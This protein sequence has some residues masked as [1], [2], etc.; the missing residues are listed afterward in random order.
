MR[1]DK[2]SNRALQRMTRRH[3]FE[4]CGV[5]LG[6]TALTSLIVGDSLFGSTAK[7]PLLEK[8]HFPP[9]AKNVIYLF[10]AG[11]PSQFE[12]W[13]RKPE[14]Q[15]LNGQPIPPSMMEGK[16]FAFMESFTK[17]PPKL[18]GTRREFKRY[19]QSG[20][21]V[22]ECFPHTAQVVDDLAF[23]RSIHT[24][25]FNHAP[26][27]IMMNTGSPIFGRPSMGSWVS[28]GIGSES[29]DLPGFVV[30][31]SGAEGTSRRGAQLGK[32]LP[33]DRAPGC[34]FPE[35]RRS[36]PQHVEPAGGL[37]PR[38]RKQRSMPFST[39]TAYSSNASAIRKS[40]PELPPM[41]W[42]TG[43]RLVDQS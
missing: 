24:D 30:L 21:W 27:K 31:Q 20:K 35:R 11:A 28:Y 23:V 7:G 2:T 43:C 34:S 42:P 1:P 41:K 8:R 37:T 36:D 38:V 6:K 17:N 32:R 3:F 10:M 33:A 18:L 5:G 40:R 39:S 22:S 9:K 29:K 13:E 4:Q 16:R 15:K 14:L 19:G 25:N 26:A 12:L